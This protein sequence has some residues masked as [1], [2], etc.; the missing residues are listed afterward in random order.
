MPFI[1][2]LLAV[3][4]CTGQCAII[5]LLEALTGRVV[6]EILRPQSWAQLCLGTILIR[7]CEGFISI[8]CFSPSCHFFFS[9]NVSAANVSAA[10]STQLYEFLNQAQSR[11]STVNH[12]E[13][14]TKCPVLHLAELTSR[15]TGRDREAGPWLPKMR[16]RE[17]YLK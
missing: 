14:Q 15:V 16:A 5:H 2:F 17:T 12:G 1:A 7:L 3:L 13:S 8:S 11:I 10:I 6:L 4:T 9:G